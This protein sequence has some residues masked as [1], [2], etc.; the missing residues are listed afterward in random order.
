MLQKAYDEIQRIYIR[1]G[2]YGNTYISEAGIREY[3]HNTTANRLFEWLLGQFKL[4]R[5][6][7]LFM[8]DQCIKFELTAVVYMVI[9]NFTFDILHFKET[10]TPH[11]WF[12]L[13]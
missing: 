12:S 4:I 11:C 2:K 13:V 3:V 7:F 8:D 6:F 5:Q 10:L 1:Q 9:N